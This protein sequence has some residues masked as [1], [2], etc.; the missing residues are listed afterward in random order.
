MPFQVFN[1][2]LKLDLHFCDLSIF[3]FNNI[4]S[5]TSL[6]YLKIFDFSADYNKNSIKIDLNSLIDL[7]CL[8]LYYLNVSINL[9]ESVNS[10][11]A[12]KLDDCEIE[13]SNRFF[14][15]LNLPELKHFHISN[16]GVYELKEN[17]FSRLKNLTSLKLV[18]IGL[19]NIDFLKCD[20]LCNLEQLDLSR[21]SI[22][23]LK[24]GDFSKLNKLK[25]L[26]LS[27]NRISD[28]V[29]NIF[30]G[31]TSLEEISMME[32]GDISHIEKDLFVGMKNLRELNLSY[33][34]RLMHIDQE[35]F[36]QVPNLVNLFLTGNNL[37]VLLNS[38]I[39]S[40]LKNLKHLYLSGTIV[41]QD[42][43]S[44]IRNSGINV[45]F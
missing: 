18:R 42:E 39:F 6:R 43:L 3:Q 7:K 11:C 28:L 20:S 38:D 27:S 36:I 26:N 24:S 30:E 32:I 1:K 40:P 25:S 12:L 35:T 22:T 19:K 34:N 45:S 5:L 10:L 44:K 16:T 13:R 4:N 33:N 21:N 8:D 17:Y 14:I 2:L 9:N 29:G 41:N 15:N 37:L 23:S 31:L